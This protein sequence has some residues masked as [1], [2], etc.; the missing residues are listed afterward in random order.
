MVSPVPAPIYLGRMNYCFKHQFMGIAY[1]SA[2]GIAAQALRRCSDEDK[3]RKI[4]RLS[5]PTAFFQARS[6]ASD[7]VSFAG[8]RCS[9]PWARAIFDADERAQ[10]ARRADARS[11]PRRYEWGRRKPP[12]GRRKIDGCNAITANP[13]HD[14]K[15]L[16]SIAFTAARQSRVFGNPLPG[17]E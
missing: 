4:F 6:Q 3:F 7:A 9:Q 16:T 5:K 8:A 15:R 14:R 1:Q 12:G 11:I 2:R 10:S 17:I 13:Q